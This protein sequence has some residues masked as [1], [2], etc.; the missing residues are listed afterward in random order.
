[1]SLPPPKLCLLRS[2]A[3]KTSLHRRSYLRVWLRGAPSLGRGAH[4]A[5]NS[6]S[7]R[8][9]GM[10]AP[11]TTNTAITQM[12]E[13]LLLWIAFGSHKILYSE[14]H[15]FSHIEHKANCVF[16]LKIVLNYQKLILAKSKKQGWFK[17]RGWNSPCMHH[18]WLSGG[19]SVIQL[20]P[21]M[22]GKAKPNAA[23]VTSG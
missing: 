11:W 14:L 7:S 16:F 23:H 12:F 10:S 3:K 5:A 9:S 1:M 17:L 15:T 20:I 13:E 8:F 4:W 19:G 21:A 18:K 2:S 22:K 6:G